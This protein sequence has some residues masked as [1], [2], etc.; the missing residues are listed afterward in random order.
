MQHIYFSLLTL[1][2]KTNK[3]ETNLNHE[4]SLTLIN[5]MILRAQNNVQKERMYSMIFWGYTTA[6]VA[7]INYVL[8]LT[9][10]NS[11]HSFWVWCLMFPAGITSAFID[12]SIHR[13]LLVKTHID[14]IGNMVWRGYLLGVVVFLVTLFSA[15]IRHHS[16]DVFIM[17]T[18]VILIMVGICEF[19]SA[20]IYRYKPWFMVAALFGVGA[21]GCVLLPASLQELQ[22]II[23]AVC[24]LLGFVVPGHLLSR[25]TKKSHV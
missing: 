11:T 17:C 19:A 4:Q 18:P 7:I 6:A 10:T 12:R 2:F 21:L 14:K 25:K 22:F 20:V 13:T 16:S 1:I 8:L 5:E 23:L 15:S 3:M 9:L 24:M